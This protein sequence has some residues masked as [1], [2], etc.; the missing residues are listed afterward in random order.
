MPAELNI[1]SNVI[2]RMAYN[3]LEMSTAIYSPCEKY[4]YNLSRRWGGG[5]KVAFIGLNPSTATE[6]V[7]DPTV[8][9]CIGYTRRWGFDGFT[10]LNAYAFRSTDP[11]GLWKVDDPIGPECD[12]YLLGEF[13]NVDRIICCWGANCTKERHA[14]L[15]EMV[16]P[17]NPH[18]LGL[19]K[20]GFPKHPL[21]L[22]GNLEPVAWG[23]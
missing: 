2:I 11:K 16:A 8:T 17:Y 19:T 20:D 4:R 10:M 23:I 9:R 1:A 6:S 13:S 15:L 22:R 21:Y 7:N 14:Q 18:H 12:E 5:P 3:L